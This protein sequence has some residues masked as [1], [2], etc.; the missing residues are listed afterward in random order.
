MECVSKAIGNDN[1]TIC[2]LCL[3]LC[4]LFVSNDAAV[5]VL[6]EIAKKVR[7]SGIDFSTFQLNVS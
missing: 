1:T 4:G 7:E 3:G 6:S 2:S 5:A